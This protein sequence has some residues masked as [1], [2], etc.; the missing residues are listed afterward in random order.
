[1]STLGF[2]DVVFASDVGRLFSVGVLI[3]GVVLMLVVLPF[4]FIRFF[5]APWLEAQV[6]LR[7][8]RRVPLNVRDH[9]IISRHD[10]IAA[11]ISEQLRL[12]GISCYIIEPDPEKAARLLHEGASVVTGDLDNKETYAGLQAQKARLLLANC[13]DTTNTNITLTV[14]EMCGDLP[15]VRHRRAPRLHR[16]SGTERMHPRPAVESAS[17][18]GSGPTGSAPALGS[19]TSS[20]VLQACRSP[21]SQPGTLHWPESRRARPSFENGP[22]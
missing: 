2:G 6:R 18:R 10:E 22:G 15:I 20:E 9:V 4:T 21:S 3:S 14:R 12:R 7:A 1:M 17:G 8:P 5:Y 13:E 19:W 11:G 16:H